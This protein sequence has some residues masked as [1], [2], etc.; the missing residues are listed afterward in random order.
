MD[1]SKTILSAAYVLYK[2]LKE[3]EAVMS[4][5][6][7]VFPLAWPDEVKKPYISFHRVGFEATYTKGA[8]SDTAE[9]EFDILTDDY[10]S[11]LELAEAVRACLDNQR[12]E[13][14]GLRLSMSK[15]TEALEDRYEEAYIQT[16]V[17]T[18]KI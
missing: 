17:F 6:N 9:V 14:G 8:V 10:D 7:G 13:E 3:D 11:G 1:A 4:K 5:C 2:W 12:G 15:L 16:L 18:V